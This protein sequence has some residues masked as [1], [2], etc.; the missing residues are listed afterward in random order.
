M[1]LARP[2]ARSTALAFLAIPTLFLLAACG[3]SPPPGEEALAEVEEG[4][5]KAGVMELL[6]AGD[7]SGLT[8]GGDPDPRV[9]HGYRTQR[10]FTG[11]ATVEVVW[12]HH[13]GTGGE[14]EDPRTELT[15]VVFRNDALD[16]WGWAHFDA[17]ATD[18]GLS[19]PPGS[20]S[21]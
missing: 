19:G 6:P 2:I 5:P 20:G 11:G 1:S 21:P 13:S 18:W 3:E 10:Y 7:L 16:G 9:T 12:L 8:E 17:R 4:T 14:A 15:P